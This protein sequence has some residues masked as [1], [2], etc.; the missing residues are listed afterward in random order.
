MLREEQTQGSRQVQIRCPGKLS[1]PTVFYILTESIV[2][3]SSLRPR[4]V[5]KSIESNSS[6]C[7]L[8]FSWKAETLKCKSQQ[9]PTDPQNSRRQPEELQELVEDPAVAGGSNMGN[10]H[11]AN[12][13]RLRVYVVKT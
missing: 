4:G 6:N 11:T 3:P 13:Q 8:K 9:R 2:E 7:V 12:Y 5:P 1:C 10:L